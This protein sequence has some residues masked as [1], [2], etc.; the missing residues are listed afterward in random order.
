MNIFKH[1]LPDHE[2]I[3]WILTPLIF[4]AVSCHIQAG[5]IL[6]YDK[7][8]SDWMME[9]LPVG[10]GT[11]GAM[12]LGGTD[13]ERI[14]FNEK[15]LWN[16]DEN[17]AGAYQAF[18]DVFVKFDPLPGGG[19]KV[20]DY[21]R[22]LDLNQAVQRTVYD[23]GGVHIVR[24]VFASHPAGVIV[25]RMKANKPGA[26]SGRLWLG[27]MHG[28]DVIVGTNEI[29]CTGL[30]NN[31]LAYASRVKVVA[32]GGSLTPVLENGYENR[33]VPRRAPETPILDGKADAYIS[34]GNATEDPFPY[35]RM[36]DTD[37]AGNPL[38][39]GGKW[40]DRGISIPSK[41]NL[42]FK[43]DGKYRW[44]SFTTELS[45]EGFITVTADGKPAGTVK[46]PGGYCCFPLSGA[47]EITISCSNNRVLQLGHLRVSPSVQQP[48]EDPGIFR[49]YS[50]E[51][52][53]DPTI[54]APVESSWFARNIAPSPLPAASLRFEK[55]DNLT[56]VIGA[57]T[58]YL[59]DRSFGWRGPHPL[60]GVI[61]RVD[62]AAASPYSE[63]LQEHV[64]DF[65]S[66][67]GR[68]SLDLGRVPAEVAAMT[69]NR[70][71]DRYAQGKP[72]PGL[73]AL[74]F[75]YGRY[76]L[77]SSSRAGGLPANLQGVWNRSNNPPWTCDHHADI[78]IEMNYWPADVSGLPECFRPLSDWM[79]ASLPVWTETTGKQFHVPGWTLRG[80]NG[81]QGGF[82]S[83]WYQA[84][85]A[86]LCRNL[87][88]HYLFTGDRDFLR[89]V[90]P[91]MKEA[92]MFWTHQ[93]VE[94][95]GGKLLTE[96]SYS[97]EHGPHETG[98]SFAQ[99]HVRD[100]F[101]NTAEAAEI[102]GVDN[103]LAHELREKRDRLLGPQIGRWGQ[104]QEWKEDID[105]PRDHH[106]HTS[107]L[108]AVYPG[109]EISPEWLGPSSWS[110][111]DE[112]FSDG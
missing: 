30:L 77:L 41:S 57:G 52:P 34:S 103:E 23:R 63:L 31:G 79:L 84:C 9:A 58:S 90:Y 94:A 28:G 29:T 82:G 106:R 62:A 39:L 50:L 85:N 74:L 83:Q 95:P 53:P 40:F 78:N 72:D 16:G 36:D 19:D 97:P 68:V 110:R 5:E 42:T 92:S 48:P 54:H 73:E 2:D 49:P 44:L 59:P 43:L 64:R 76:L 56:V 112:M 47:K 13:W 80:H 69:T 26:F 96:I 60:D 65:S 6:R 100:L 86:W 11:M 99:Q 67:F 93:L 66:L 75:Q 32:G 12:V 38:I 1:L 8:A 98:V 21:E 7:P 37:I 55:C 107:H 15:S 111:S 91:L 3:Q 104:L 17:K 45:C 87:W 102:L 70:R 10:N 22:T 20:S 24:E 108:V 25:I 89:S 101:E 51:Q 61:R 33:P 35:T 71:L 18:G 81:I 88:D 109:T 14:Q 105:D 27:D 4:L 46:A